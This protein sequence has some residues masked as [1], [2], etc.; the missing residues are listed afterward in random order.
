[1]IKLVRSS[2]AVQFVA[3]F[4]MFDLLCVG[5]VQAKG[6]LTTSLIE[7]SNKAAPIKVI[8][9]T[10]DGKYPIYDVQGEATDTTYKAGN[11]LYTS[12]DL[13][14]K[15]IFIDPADTKTGAYN[16]EF[17]CKDKHNHTV[18]INPSFKFLVQ[19]GK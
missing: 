3:L 17:L 15:L 11:R 2:V 9:N 7:W 1:M 13:V 14:S 10:D 19:K 18:G 6:Y 5:A 12:G 4:L 8:G 16:C